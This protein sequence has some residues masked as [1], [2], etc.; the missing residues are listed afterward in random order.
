MS[1]TVTCPGTGEIPVAIDPTPDLPAGII[2]VT[3]MGLCPFCNANV[4]LRAGRLGEHGHF[5]IGVPA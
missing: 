5:I 4:F 2:G 3:Q 1:A